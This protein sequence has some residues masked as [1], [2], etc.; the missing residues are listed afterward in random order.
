[1]FDIVNVNGCMP[2]AVNVTRP[3]NDLGSKRPQKTHRQMK[4]H[5][6]QNAA[7]VRS[8]SE[9]A[10]KLERVSLTTTRTPSTTH[11]KSAYL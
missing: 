5:T 11:S 4:V 2:E 7:R 3:D 8:L 10:T 1:M 6:A 9:A